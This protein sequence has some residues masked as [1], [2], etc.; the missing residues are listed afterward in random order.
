MFRSSDIRKLKVNQL[1]ALDVNGQA[2]IRI[3]FAQAKNDQQHIGK[4]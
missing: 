3:R 1:E 4:R 2:A